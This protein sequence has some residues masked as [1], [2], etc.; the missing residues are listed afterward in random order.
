MK[1]ENYPER[2][3]C[4]VLA[5]AIW[6][7]LAPLPVLAQMVTLG[8][9]HWNITL[10]DYGYSDFLLDNT[11]GFEGREYLSG[12]WAAA[13]AYQVAGQPPLPPQWLEPQFLYPDWPTGSPFHVVT[14][15]GT[16]VLN[17]DNLPV[18]ESVIASQDL[19]ITLRYEMLDTVVGTPMGITPTSGAGP[20]ASIAS[21]R[22]VLKQ[23]ATLRNISGAPLTNLQF[24]QF[25]HG[26]QSQRGVYDNRAYAGPLGEFRHDTTL[27]GVDAWA[28]GAGSSPAGLEDF[29]GFHG[30]AAPS[31]LEIGYYGIEGNGI[32]D[33]WSSKPSDGVHY[34]VENNWQTPPY[35]SRLGTDNFAPPQR[36]IAGAQRWDL[37][38][39]LAPGASVSLDILLSVRSGTR[40]A[41][42]GG[43]SGGC[44]G[45]SSVPGGLDYEFDDVSEDGSFFAEYAQ[46]DDDELQVHV[47]EGEFASLD[48]PLPA[49]PA[50][51]WK[52]WFTGT[53]SGAVHLK[54]GYDAT[55]LPPGFDENALCLYQFDGAQWQRLPGMVDPVGNKI[56]V[57]VNMLAPLALGAGAVTTFTVS[58]EAVPPEGGSVTGAGAYVDGASVT[59]VATPTS[60]Y[61]FLNWKE[62]GTAVSTSPSYTFILRADRTLEAEFLLV[63]T[64][65]RIVAT[66]SLPSHGGTT[67]GDGAY[68][69]GATATVTATPAP[70][71]K[72]SKWLDGET[73]LS[74]APSYSF[75]VAGDLTLVAKFKPVYM[76]TLIAEPTEGGELEGDPFYE[77][78]ELV[79][80][81][82]KPNDG[83]SFVNWTQNGLPV[84]TDPNFQFNMSGNREL[85]GH[86]TL[87][88]R[89][90]ASS[91]PP[92]AGTISGKGVYQ[93][94]PDEETAFVT[95]IAT[96]EPGYVFLNWTENGAV[97]SDS[98]TYSF[99]SQVG[100][101]FVAN[102]GLGPEI[103]VE[104]PAGNELVDGGAGVDFG[105]V[106][107]G[108]TSAVQTFTI[109]NVGGSDLT[110]LAITK[111]GP[112][113]ADFT[114]DAT[115]MADA[116][117]PGESTTFTVSFIPSV[118]GPRSATLH[119]ASNDA[120]ENP[121]EV[122]LTG[123]GNSTPA[124]VNIAHTRAPGMSL[125]IA[126]VDL[127][128]LCSDPDGD[129]LALDSVGASAQGTT[130]DIA[131][132]Y[133]LYESPNNNEDTFP[134]TIIDSRGARASG[135][136]TV[137]VVSPG[138]RVQAI[139]AGPG[140][141]T[142]HF[143]GIPGFRYDIER[144][145][146]VAFT[147]N[148]EVIQT[149]V[150]P[151]GPFAYTDPAPPQ[152][153]A[154]Y[155]LKYNPTP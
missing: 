100:R 101:S 81:K 75:T 147:V 57:T 114:V 146:D 47:A 21:S 90:D 33:H 61:A 55:M 41:R 37:A 50:Q 124:A 142:I 27:A 64:G 22:Y 7:L 63:G 83:Y 154:F 54:V 76:L 72:F 49:K 136:V 133:I 88:V 12:E 14:P 30:N 9:P 25:L 120:N 28:V 138:G 59:V 10:T 102:F 122:P 116:L 38:P 86:F 8:N 34:S 131:E 115:A 79:Q 66:S 74:T 15:F 19:E 105:H 77:P 48:F 87:G 108:T 121:F 113:A 3:R 56:S 2:K 96:P 89:I 53:F 149:V 70:G 31:A 71:Y 107:P 69:L 148:A 23:T 1:S 137:N 127:L 103:A 29:I 104:E 36:W 17:A 58:A 11:P 6:C 155:R 45:G 144:A 65:A 67:S 43:S 97:V 73:V 4:L 80:L 5:G 26:L 35:S 134:Y 110:G 143:T 111:D 46:A 141:V 60:G 139:T 117:A 44:N 128:G 145:T 130:L 20:A 62:G 68:A 119:I 51:I 82:A 92:H 125:K 126:V 132:G 42:G 32:D 78:G 91:I 39:T 150:A 118:L 16:P 129:P 99:T 109:R 24:F 94:D 18:V 140:G 123:T 85:I 152:P 52:L 95:L 40:V 106:P 112:A 153:T 98:A 13:V 151:R 84:S 135:V 93:L